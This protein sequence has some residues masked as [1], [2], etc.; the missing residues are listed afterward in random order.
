MSYTDEAWSLGV[1]VRLAWPTRTLWAEAWE[2]V[3]TGNEDFNTTRV[4][5]FWR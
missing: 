4:F 2:N 1:V 3:H 5:F